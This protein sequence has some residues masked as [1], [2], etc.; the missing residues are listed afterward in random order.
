MHA[1]HSS[2]AS[3]LRR[4]CA[5]GGSS[6]S[7]GFFT[8]PPPPAPP[9][10]LLLLEEEDESE[11]LSDPLP[12]LSFLLF[13]SL[14]FFFLFFS[15]FFRF[16]SSFLRFFSSFFLCGKK[17][18][19][20]GVGFTQSRLGEGSQHKEKHSPP[21]ASSNAGGPSPHFRNLARKQ[22]T[23]PA[24][25]SCPFWTLSPPVRPVAAWTRPQRRRRRAQ[26][27]RALEIHRRRCGERG[28]VVRAADCERSAEKEGGRPAATSKWQR[29]LSLGELRTA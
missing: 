23:N 29:E 3:E 17:R 9:P 24:P 22:K 28:R 8:F 4:R 12:R 10:L 14:S 7:L 20:R 15:S 18:A 6:S 5:P 16:F 27:R 26:G 11:S 1:T 21:H 2:G 19:G 13:L 25:A